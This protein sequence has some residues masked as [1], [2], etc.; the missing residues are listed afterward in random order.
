MNSHRNKKTNK[1]K[2][3]FYILVL[4]SLSL[5]LSAQVYKTVTVSAGG[6]SAALTSEEKS[7]V[8]DLTING[9]IDARDFKTMRDSISLLTEIDISG[10][11]VVSYEGT[12]GT[13]QSIL[14]VYYPDNIVPDYAFNENSNLTTICLSSTVISIGE[15]AFRNCSALTTISLPPS[16]SSIKSEAFWNCTS[17][18]TIEVGWPVPINLKPST[19]IFYSVNKTMCALKVPYGTTS[20]YQTAYGWKDFT[21]IVELDGLFLQTNLFKFGANASEK[22]LNIASSAE[23]SAVSDQSWLTLNPVSGTTGCNSITFSA[24]LY[25]ST[26][27]RTAIVTISATGLEDKAVQIVQYE[28]TEVSAGGLSAAL[29][30]EEKD[31]ITHLTIWGFIDARDFKTMRDDMPLLAELDLS[32]ATIMHYRGNDGTSNTPNFD[33]PANMIPEYAFNDGGLSWGKTTL[34]SI[35]FPTSIT[36]IGHYAFAKCTGLTEVSIP[37][38]VTS[39]ESFAF[40]NSTNL[41]SVFVNWPIPIEIPNNVFPFESEMPGCI[42]YVPYGTSALYNSTERWNDFFDDFEELPGIFLSSNKIG[43]GTSGGDKMLNIASSSA[44]TAVSDQSWLTLDPNDGAIGSS[45]VTLSTTIYPSKGKRTATVTL[46][47]TGIDDQTVVVTQYGLIE[48]TEGALRDSLGDDLICNTNLTLTGTIDARDFKTMRDDMPALNTIDLSGVTIIAYNGSDGTSYQGNVNYP[49]NTVPESAFYKTLGLTSVILPPSTTVLGTSSFFSCIGL[50]SI[51]LPS[52]VTT[53]ESS[54][55][56]GCSGLTTINIPTSVSSIASSTFRDCSNLDSINIPSSIFSIGSYAFSGCSGLTEISIP[57]SVSSIK[58]YAFYNCTGITSVTVG[59][60]IPIS[61]SGEYFVFRNINKTTCVLHVPFGSKAL[62]NDAYQWEDFINVVE[63]E[64]IFLQ[65]NQLNFGI[66]GGNEE[67]MI[68]SSGNWAA[69]SDQSWLTLD[70]DSGANGNYPITFSASAAYTSTEQ[71]TA[72]VVFSA[73]GFANQNVEITQDMTLEVIAGNLSNK[74]GENLSTITHLKLTGTIDARD[75][76]TMRDS[77]PTLKDIDLY[78]VNIEAYNGTEGTNPNQSNYP[79]NTIPEWAFSIQNHDNLLLSSIVLPLSIVEIDDYAFMNCKMLDSIVVPQN[80][81]RIGNYAF[82]DCINLTGKMIIPN[83]INSIGPGCFVNCYKL[84]IEIPSNLTSIYEGTF[85]SCDSIFVDSENPNYSSEEGVFYNHD[86]TNLYHCPVSKEGV[87]IIPPSVDSIFH[88]SFYRCDSL[89]SVII[90]P[91]VKI[92]GGQAFGL[93]SNLN[94]T[95][96]IPSGVEFIDDYAFYNCSRLDT[97]IIDAEISTI[98]G[99]LFYNCAELKHIGLNHS[100]LIVSI[101]SNAFQNTGIDS[102]TIP[103]QVTSI[104]PSTFRESLSLRSVIFHNGI[105]SIGEYA[106]YRCPSFDSLTLPDGLSSLGRYCFSECVGLDSISIPPLV[107]SIQSSTFRKCSN[108]SSVNLHEGLTSIGDY[109]FYECSNLNSVSLPEGLLTIGRYSFRS[110]TQLDSINIPTTIASI[111][112]QAFAYCSG[113]SSIAVFPNPPVDLSSSS[114]VFFDVDKTTCILY[115][116]YGTS[117]LYKAANQWKDFQNIVEMP[118]FSLSSNAETVAAPDGST[119]QVDIHSNTSWTAESDQAWLVVDPTSGSGN[120][121]LTFTAEAN[122]LEAPREATVTVSADDVAPQTVTITQE[123]GG[124]SVPDN[125]DF[126]ETT[127]TD[128]QTECYNAQNTITVA[129]DGTSVVFE[130]GSS[131]TLIAG[132]SIC[133]LPGFHAQNGSYMSAIITTTGTFCDGMPE[134]VIVEYTAPMVHK[135]ENIEPEK[136]IQ[137]DAKDEPSL[138]VYPNPTRGETRFELNNFSKPVY[139]RIFNSNGVLVEEIKEVAAP[140]PTLQLSHLRKGLYF[141]CV[142]NSNYRTTRKLVIE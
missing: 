118:G 51:I 100:N 42:L 22:I 109:A 74:L 18:T 19:N 17:L 57:S 93:C 64:G 138:R 97:V 72:T 86:K 142:G 136:E 35:V 21:N 128:N 44:W 10:A 89:T 77:M 94:G 65:T 75:F 1:M 106:F 78:N 92:I 15:R 2:K 101:G 79:E 41:T 6:L 27:Q 113:L 20:L 61:L 117:A 30:S 69:V 40:Y 98:E 7:T 76:K 52:S 67:I 13:R 126:P 48:V 134:Q 4:I 82:E 104:E 90:P 114:T 124:P 16:V 56:S 139:I 12:N 70:P 34:T 49:E 53:I 8:T 130:S 47:A 129:G 127:L 107:T 54:A 102:F 131:A 73:P 39:I 71:R 29:T 80:I 133:F 132:Y 3:I 58:Q 103:L 11:K 5:N 46:S 120:G 141:V 87:F 23:W 55:F 59:W 81:T 122:P 32:E 14:G 36:S 33:Y 63:M 38:S 68:A 83:S 66:N 95:L 31:T 99:G 88:Q 9:T 43:F 119:A 110:C 123:A 137:N 112:S 115:V 140:T 108:L 28:P 84:S 60:P 26:G 24:A 85:K 25:P 62:Y 135:S 111:S 105:T 91:T 116:P 121:T 96:N 45:T 37:N 50:D 125:F